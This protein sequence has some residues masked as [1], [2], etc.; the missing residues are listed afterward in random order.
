LSKAFDKSRAS[1]FTVVPTDT[2]V[3][4][5]PQHI[6]GIHTADILF[7]SK[8][9]ITGFKEWTITIIYTMFEYF[10][11]NGADRYTTKV[12]YSNSLA[13]YIGTV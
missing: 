9:V 8:L 1:L 11:Y 13:I 3:N 4:G 12:I 2:L 5:R 10:R 7:E 6:N